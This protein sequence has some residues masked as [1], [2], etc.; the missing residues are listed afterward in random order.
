MCTTDPLFF[1]RSLRSD[2]LTFLMAKI[3]NRTAMLIK[4]FYDVRAVANGVELV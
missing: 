2:V 4:C 1:K 3:E